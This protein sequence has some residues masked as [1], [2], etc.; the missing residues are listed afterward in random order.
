MDAVPLSVCLLGPVVVRDGAGHPVDV[1]GPR[2]RALLARLALEPGRVVGLDTL[3]EAVW[4]ADPPAAPGNALQALVSRLRRAAPELSLRAQAHGYLLD[5]PAD[6]VD[7]GRFET[8]TA[9]ARAEADAARVVALLSEAEQLWRGPALADLRDLAFSAAPV[10]R[11]EE[12]R[13]TAAEQRLA[14]GIALGQPA[15]ALAELEELVTDHPLREPLCVLQVRA[16]RLL[17]RPADALAAY[18]RCRAQ[19]ADELGLDPSPALQ[20]EQLAVLRGQ[21]PEPEA[22]APRGGS[23][24]RSTLTSFLGREAELTGVQRLLDA[25]RLVTLL[26][27][28]GAGK[29]RLALESAHRRRAAVPDGVWWVELAPVADARLLPAAVLAAVGQREGTSL[30]RVPTLVEAGDRL[31]ETF[32]ERRALLVLDNCE[33]LV[34]AV[35]ELTD[36]LLAHCPALSVL[37]TSREPLG[38]PGEAVLPVGPLD[39]PEAGAD[40]AA[41]TPVVRLFADRAAA[42]RPGFSVTAENLPAVLEVCARLDGM[43]LALELAAARL[44]SLSV[45]QIADR[46]DDRFSLLTGG[47]RVALPRHQT[48]R[49]VVEWSWEALDERERAVARRLSV[50]SGGAALDAAEEVCAD[51]GWPAGAV[52]DAVTGLVE[53]SMLLAAEGSDGSV[54][55][56]MLETIRAYGGEQLDAAGERA[57]VEAAQTAWCLRLVDELEPRL[58]RADQLGALHR[59]RAEHDALVAVLQRLIAARDGD[60][61]VHLAGRLT[62]YWFLS[63]MQVAGA[64]WLTQ[65]VELPGGPSPLR[66]ACLA[67][68]AML[69]LEGGDWGVALRALQAVADLPEADTWASDDATAAVAWG[70][71]VMFTGRGRTVDALAR[72][73]S[74]PDPWVVAMAHGV[75]AQVAENDGDPETLESDLELARAEFTRLGDRWG[76]SITAAALAQLR[77]TEGDL[78]GAAAA[79]EETIAL[80][81]ELG[82]HE[83]TPMMQVRL[84]L[85]RAAAGETERAGR[86]VAAV[87][88]AVDGDGGMVLSFAESG[89][90]ELALLDGRLDDA[91]RWYRSA[92]ARLATVTVGPPQIASSA[93]SGLATTLALRVEAGAD[94]ALLAEAA[95]QLAGATDLAVRMAADMPVAA[96]AVQA[97]AALALAEGDPGRAGTLLGRASAVRGRRDHAGLVGLVVERRVRAVLGDEE[98]ERRH[99]AGAATPRA[100]VFADLGVTYTGGW[101]GAMFTG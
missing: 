12:L 50:F 46:L 47:S 81:E 7:A 60:A 1:G 58:R 56:R 3:V 33:H 53:K 28:G 21:P 36:T 76:R 31:Q 15:G 65:V 63:G 9:R 71:A 4:D 77:A 2:A 62:W 37:T 5:L 61:A 16:L 41:G 66:T 99:A 69:Q 101:P 74:H 38:V 35:A 95:E 82:T 39:V 44:R 27:P 70:M 24:L 34:A 89:T 72:L 67:F 11:L 93:Q 98:L 52:L 86:E 19:L 22:P 97:R 54:R 85:V 43:P 45:Q 75:R 26:G 100:D 30:E 88:A 17:G 94:P 42:V 59:L 14:A 91:E 40:G 73:A 51:P 92:L 32:A 18:D 23:P 84:A 79:F 64:R 8:L 90:A 87:R 49:A 13:L 25:G 20:A 96:I 78:A 68:S 6:A 83:D 29:T 48:L 55:Y 57:A 80:S 10:A